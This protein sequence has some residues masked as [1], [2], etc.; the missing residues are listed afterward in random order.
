MLTDK[1]CTGKRSLQQPQHALPVNVVFE[2]ITQRT[3]EGVGV[4]RK[5]GG[6]YSVGQERDKKKHTHMINNH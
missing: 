1:P 5:K 3:W 4:Q 2:G 6:M